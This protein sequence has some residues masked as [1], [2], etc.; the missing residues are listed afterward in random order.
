MVKVSLAQA[1]TPGSETGGAIKAPLMG[2]SKL[3]AFSFPGVNAWATEKS[4][5]LEHHQ[6]RALLRGFSLHLCDLA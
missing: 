4:F 5:K 2:L 1:F 3:T 6:A